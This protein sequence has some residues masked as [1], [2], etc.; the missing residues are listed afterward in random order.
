MKKQ[1]LR[2]NITHQLL[3]LLVPTLGTAF[4]YVVGKTSRNIEF[5][6]ERLDA[7][8]KEYPHVIYIGWHEHV[9]TSAWMLR[10]QQIALLISQSRDGEYH[11][12][13]ARSLGFR[14]V[15]GSSS[16][17]GVRSLLQLAHAVQHE[18]DVLIG[19]DGPRGPAK[20]CKAGAI[21]L[22]KHS[23]MPII[24]MSGSLTR[25]TRLNSWDSTIV[26]FPC[27][28]LIMGYGEPIFVPTR[29]DK[30][31]IARYQARV[32]EAIDRLT[33]QAWARKTLE[34][35]KIPS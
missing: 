17:G 20:E 11:S 32:K 9:L 12:R 29:A 26:P 21:V 27:S 1:T 18:S 16:R 33:E 30:H 34:T 4:L 6:R 10:H 5:G 24:P 22:A 19:A 15:R 23:G 13:L 2:K 14:P 28:T 8:R 31:T 3:K 25:Y 35:K 7:L